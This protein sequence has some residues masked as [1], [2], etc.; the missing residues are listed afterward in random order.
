MKNARIIR[1][2]VNVV[3]RI[4]RPLGIRVIR[5]QKEGEKPWDKFFI[6]CIK[7]YKRTGKDPN[8]ILNEDWKNEEIFFPAYL[9]PLMKRGM[10][11]L[12]V[13]PGIGRYTRHVLPYCREIYLIDYSQY[14]CEFL[15]EYFKGEKGIHIIHMEGEKKLPV[16][17]NSV[18]LVFTIS[19]FVHLYTETIYWYFE[20]FY[21]VLCRGAS[22]D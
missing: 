7:E 18:D 4:I 9:K 10:I 3:N 21:R 22:I 19:T 2:S 5:Y 6:D 8:N 13:G 16:P 12:E 11:A 15:R 20:E 17:D 1:F 14:C